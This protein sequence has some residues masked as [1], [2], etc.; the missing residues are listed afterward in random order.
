MFMRI[1]SELLIWMEEVEPVAHSLRERGNRKEPVRIKKQ[2]VPIES[3]WKNNAGNELLIKNV[4]GPLLEI[5][6]LYKESESYNY[7]PG[8]KKDSE[9]GWRYFENRFR[10]IYK[11]LNE[12]LY[13]S[14]KVYL[15]VF[16]ICE[17]IQRFVRSF[18]YAEG[19][20]ERF[21][22]INPNLR[23]YR[24]AF[25]LKRQDEEAYEF[26]VA[27]GAISYIPTRW[28]FLKEEEYFFKKNRLN[29]EYNFHYDEEDY[30]MEEL[31][32]TVRLI[33]FN[34]LEEY[35]A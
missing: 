17:E 7:V 16:R 18:S 19:L 22:Q 15:K 26:A 34:D 5:I 13:I 33:F 27:N 2:L 1:K 35:E 23:F 25:A 3:R 29:Y 30:F 31:A 14:Q 12:N 21:F 24:M 9:A 20:E 11:S 8:T 32:Y 28:D 4:L 6:Y 10:E